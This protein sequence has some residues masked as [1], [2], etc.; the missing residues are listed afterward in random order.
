MYIFLCILYLY[1]YLFFLFYIFFDFKDFDS[2]ISLLNF[3]YCVKFMFV[4]CWSYLYKMNV[5]MF[6]EFLCVVVVCRLY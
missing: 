2:L 3:L 4:Y 6:F 1:K 5:Y